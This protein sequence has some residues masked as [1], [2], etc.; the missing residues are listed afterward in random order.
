MTAMPNTE[1]VHQLYYG[2]MEQ[3][4]VVRILAFVLELVAAII[5]IYGRTVEGSPKLGYGPLFAVLLLSGS[6]VLRSYAKNIRGYAEILRVRIVRAVAFEQDVGPAER[7]DADVGAPW[8]ASWFARRSSCPTLAAY[9][10]PSS[11]P[12]VRR[13]RELVAQNAFFT[14][15]LL[16][17]TAIV[18]ATVAIFALVYVLCYLYRYAVNPLPTDE[19]VFAFDFLLTVIVALLLL[20]S[21][22]AWLGAWRIHQEIRL[23]ETALGAV[24][25]DDHARIEQ[26]VR[27]YDQEVSRAPEIFTR[28]YRLRGSRIGQLWETRRKHY[29]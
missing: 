27:A 8:L 16:R 15:Q 26:L 22:D 1:H 29:V 4:K 24:P 6:V 18:W 13:L 14:F 19:V 3:Q 21:L 5:A 28:V 7:T 17:T 9:Y 10:A 20:R 11:G 25:P 2:A 23:I 12:G